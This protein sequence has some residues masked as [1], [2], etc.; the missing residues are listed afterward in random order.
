MVISNRLSQFKISK[1]NK[2]GDISRLLPSHSAFQIE[3]LVEFRSEVD[4]ELICFLSLN[5]LSIVLQLIVRIQLVKLGLMATVVC[6]LLACMLLFVASI[7][8]TQVRPMFTLHCPGELLSTV[9][10]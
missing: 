9:K 6:P 2:L 10:W 3:T 7:Q 5:V 1:V 8:D 4:L